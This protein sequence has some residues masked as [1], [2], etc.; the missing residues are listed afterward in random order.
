MPTYHKSKK[1]PKKPRRVKKVAGP[2]VLVLPL[3]EF[4]TFDGEDTT[5]RQANESLNSTAIIL[6]KILNAPYGYPAALR[7]AILDVRFHVRAGLSLI[8]VYL[9]AGYY[10]SDSIENVDGLMSCIHNHL[11]ALRKAKDLWRYWLKM[12]KK[13]KSVPTA[14]KPVSTTLALT[15]TA[16]KLKSKK[17]VADFGYEED[18]DDLGFG[19]YINEEDFGCV[20]CVNGFSEG[21]QNTLKNY[22]EPDSWHNYVGLAVVGVVGLIV[23]RVLR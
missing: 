5:V 21:V 7:Q 6:D 10:S 14:V 17:G 22:S 1:P 16:T 23:L 2:S 20:G 15:P 4:R 13:E 19:E 12:E 9:G 18:E 8:D 11:R 3:E